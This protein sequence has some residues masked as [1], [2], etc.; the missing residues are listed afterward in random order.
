MGKLR[1]SSTAREV[2]RWMFNRSAPIPQVQEIVADGA[3]GEFG[4][5]WQDAFKLVAAHPFDHFAD[6]LFGEAGLDAFFGTVALV[7]QQIEQL[8]HILIGKAKFAFIRLAGPQVGGRGFGNDGF[9][10]LQ[11]P[12]QLAHL[13]LVQ[14]AD[15]VE[16]AGRIAV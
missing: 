3:A 8:V 13:G 5:G 16:R 14:I 12:G 15:R 9:G 6:E 7:Y 1:G 11:G 2:K 10:D 4:D